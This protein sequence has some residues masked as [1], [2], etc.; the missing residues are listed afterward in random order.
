MCVCVCVCLCARVFPVFQVVCVCVSDDHHCFVFCL[1]W[2]CSLLGCCCCSC[3]FGFASSCSAFVPLIPVVF[4]IVAL[5]VLLALVLFLLFFL[6]F[7]FVIV[8]LFLFLLFL[9]LFLVLFF[10]LVANAL[11]FD[12]A[13]FVKYVFAKNRR[14]KSQRD[15]IN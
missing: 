14:K 8:F 6:L 11:P 1:F 7:L 3:C 10:L 12:S 13:V 9:F 15:R 4:A 2:F 5:A